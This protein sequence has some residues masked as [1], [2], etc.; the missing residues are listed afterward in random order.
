MNHK[1]GV[2][3]SAGN[4]RGFGEFL[5]K[6]ADAGAPVPVIFA[7][8]QSVWLDVQQN[9]PNTLVIFRHQPKQYGGRNYRTGLDTPP[10][11]Y[12]A[13]PV[14]AARTWMAEL[15]PVWRRN[16]AHYYAL[17]NEQDAGTLAG[18]TWLNAFTL[19]C[20]EI[21]EANRF[22]C[23]VYGHSA[24]NP[25]DDPALVMA[26]KS[27]LAARRGLAV[28]LANDLVVKPGSAEEK[29]REL[30]PSLQRAKRNGHIHLLHEYGFDSPAA[31]GGPTNSLR[32]SAPNLALR[33][34][35]TQALLAQYDADAKIVISEASA[36]VGAFGGL[37]QRE[38]VADAVWY[39]AQ[40]MQAQSVIGCCLY[41]VGGAENMQPALGLLADA[42][43]S[44]KP[45][46]PPVAI[47]VWRNVCGSR[48]NIR[49]TPDTK[50][51]V[52]GQ[53]AVNGTVQT[54]D[55]Y[56]LSAGLTW[57]KTLDGAW[58]CSQTE[59]QTLLERVP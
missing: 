3:V 25:R 57:W 59:D 35:R 50:A 45:E 34:R 4:R 5:K 11:T 32:A 53:V 27:W 52:V 39:N 42:L 2:H 56:T 49:A 14:T 20:L 22:K 18:Y 1:L 24:G 33:Y 29:L 55:Q 17:I 41:Q 43:A 7:V 26:I 44:L 6:C 10:D 31:N 21:A 37:S 16:P 13:D 47:Y 28:A 54:T 46:V 36:G 40:L 12:R 8:D 51:R 38:W 30:V 58:V 48:V 19:H 15:L 23:A 9:S